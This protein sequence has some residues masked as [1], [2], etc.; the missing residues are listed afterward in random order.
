MVTF[1]QQNIQLKGD[2]DRNSVCELFEID[3]PFS[4][5]ANW[6]VDLSQAKRIDSAGLALFIDWNQRAAKN[7]SRLSVINASEDFLGLV[8]LCKVDLLIANSNDD[9]A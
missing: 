9:N 2:I 7:G 3:I 1:Q 5:F 4:R 6:Y 8:R